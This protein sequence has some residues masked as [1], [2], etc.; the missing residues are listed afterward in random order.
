MKIFLFSQ[1]DT[2]D[3]KSQVWGKLMTFKEY[4]N[5]SDSVNS[6]EHENER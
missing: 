2:K 3:C 5:K 6:H 4:D 1:C